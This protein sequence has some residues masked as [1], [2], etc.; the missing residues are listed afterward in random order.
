MGNVRA[1][2]SDVKVPTVG[3]DGVITDLTADVL[4][5]T[6]YYPFGMQMPGR[7]FSSNAYRYGFKDRRKMMK[8]RERGIL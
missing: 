6:D 1:V 4:S 7:S 5:A 3:G 2:V 8:L